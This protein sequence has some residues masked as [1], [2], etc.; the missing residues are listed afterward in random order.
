[1]SSAQLGGGSDDQVDPKPFWKAILRFDKNGDGRFGR[2]E[3][4]EH[5][6]WPLRPELPLGHPGWGLPLPRDQQ[7]RRERQQ[8]IFGWVDKDKDDFWTEDELSAH[9]ST[10]RGRPRLIAIRPGGRGQLGK[11]HIAWELH[12]SIP[13][14]PSPLFYRDRLYLV[15]NGGLLAAINPDNG[16]QLYRGRLGGP[17]G[18]SA[19]PIAAN[20]HL[21]LLSDEGIVSV[22]KAGPKFELIHRHELGEAA[23]VTPAIDV[24]TIYIRGEKHLWAFRRAN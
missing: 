2:D 18:Y 16:R 9:M 14:I 20:D 1:V 13:E 24:D 11:E 23:T 21:Y 17:G 12:R 10:R 7:R 15:R 22:T 6:T 4:T 5:F 3:I 19:S 8:G